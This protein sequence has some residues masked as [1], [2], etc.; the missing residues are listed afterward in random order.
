[1][2]KAWR[3]AQNSDSDARMLFMS[4]WHKVGRAC[5]A[6]L[7]RSWRHKQCEDKATQFE[8]PII[9]DTKKNSV[10]TTLNMAIPLTFLRKGWV[11]FVGIVGQDSGLL[12]SM[13]PVR[14]ELTLLQG[15]SERSQDLALKD[16]V[17]KALEV[18]S[19]PLYP[20][21]V[22]DCPSWHHPVL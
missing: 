10:V 1:M 12:P 11:R 15:W 6:M 2:L 18:R 17:W 7:A 9:M 16:V 5:D 13:L 21:Q 3:K 8:F 19:P 4:P 22:W 20:S 14:S